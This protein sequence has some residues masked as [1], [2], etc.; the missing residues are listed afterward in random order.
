MS[1]IKAKCA[2]GEGFQAIFPGTCQV[3][4]FTGTTGQSSAFGANTTIVRL[5]ATE[6]CHVVF[7]SSPTAVADGTCIFLPADQTE[8]FGVVGGQKLAVIRDSVSGNLFIT[9]G[10]Q[11]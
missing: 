8:Y 1:S 9:E 3:K 4:A 6:D 2:P 10:A 7:G 11:T 5:H